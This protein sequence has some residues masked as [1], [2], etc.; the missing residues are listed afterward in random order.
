MYL[1]TSAVA[2]AFGT[3]IPSFE[4]HAPEDIQEALEDLEDQLDEPS[5]DI[6]TVRHDA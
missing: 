3:T 6:A 2:I 1:L 5:T 4:G